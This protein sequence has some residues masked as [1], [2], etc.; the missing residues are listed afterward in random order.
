MW[1]ELRSS[2]RRESSRGGCLWDE[3]ILYPETRSVEQYLHWYLLL[4]K[5]HNSRDHDIADYTFQAVS[6]TNCVSYTHQRI[7]NY[8]RLLELRYTAVEDCL[9][10][11]VF[12]QQ[13]QILPLTSHCVSTNISHKSHCMCILPLLWIPLPT[14][15]ET[16]TEGCNSPQHPRT[17]FSKTGP[18]SLVV[19]IFQ[20]IDYWQD[21]HFEVCS[22]FCL[23]VHW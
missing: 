16:L 1:V 6:H 8:V 23:T 17:S 4:L 15:L 5:P 9:S 19:K 10:F 7:W 2:L 22:V 20:V 11:E 14:Q 18:V 12:T 13:E 21:M 3:R